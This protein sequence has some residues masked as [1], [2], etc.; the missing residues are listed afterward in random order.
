MKDVNNVYK[1][2]NVLLHANGLHDRSLSSS[3]IYNG[4]RKKYIAIY[5]Y[6]SL[7]DEQNFKLNLSCIRF[8]SKLN[9]L[10]PMYKHMMT[11]WT[12][13]CSLCISPGNIVVIMQHIT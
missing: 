10:I 9:K 4:K 13:P 12:I 7:S 8:W 6:K 11:A 3:N 1:T 5:L 2:L